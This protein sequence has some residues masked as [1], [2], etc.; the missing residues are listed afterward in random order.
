MYVHVYRPKR[1]QPVASTELFCQGILQQAAVSYNTCSTHAQGS[2]ASAASTA[3][4]H[5]IGAE[6]HACR[7][8]WYLV[9]L[10]AA[11]NRV[12]NIT[13]ALAR[14]TSASSCI[15]VAHMHTH[16]VPAHNL[17][18]S[19]QAIQNACAAV[20]YSCCQ[21]HAMQPCTAQAAVLQPHAQQ[22]MLEAPHVES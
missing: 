17:P 3:S 15:H 13:P 20:Q 22:I 12:S 21:G 16:I 18:V 7:Q 4:K 9:A 14:Y 1:H 5:A 8:I 19:K 6:H 11:E 2:K 10:Y